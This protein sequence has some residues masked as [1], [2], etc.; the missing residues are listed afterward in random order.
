MIL[1]I[2]FILTALATCIAAVMAVFGITN[3]AMSASEAI[4]RDGLH[5]GMPA[6]SWSLHTSSGRVYQSPSTKSLQLIVFADHSL[7]SFPSVVEG[8]RELATGAAE[9]EIII[10]LRRPSQVA[11]PMLRLLGMGDIPVAIG[12]P[13]LYGRYNVRV[14]PFVIFVDSDGR[15][16]ASSMINQSWQIMKLWRL[17]NVPL[18]PEPG[19]APG[20]FR[21]RLLH[22]G[23]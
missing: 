6:P 15:V 16:R 10:L 4:E 12:S 11:E 2:I 18:A 19:L 8:L 9:L 23:I 7:K 14:M 20:R 1:S 22:G 3:F 5:R 17:A 13:S 21:Q